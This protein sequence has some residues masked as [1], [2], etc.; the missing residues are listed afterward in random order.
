MTSYNFGDVV[1]VPFPCT[2]QTTNKK[3]PAVVIS[4]EVYNAEY[5]DRILMGITSQVSSSPKVGDI[6]ITD[7]GSAGLLKASMIKPVMMNYGRDP[8]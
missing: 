5:P 2:D 3:C 1:L 4:S 8:F 6:V 7:W